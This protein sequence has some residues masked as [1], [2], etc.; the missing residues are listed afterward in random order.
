MH[1][2]EEYETNDVGEAERFIGRVYDRARFRETADPFTFRQQ[3]SGGATVSVAKYT[4]SSRSELAVEV[5]GALVIGT[6]AGADFR[7]ATNGQALDTTVPFLYRPGLAQSWA[8]DLQSTLVNLDLQALA[9]HAG[10][11]SARGRLVVPSTS[12]VTR[13]GAAHWRH[14]AAHTSAVFATPALVGNDLVRRATE[15]L[16]L[17]AAINSF[18]MAVEGPGLQGGGRAL[19][20]ALRRATAY[21]DDNADSPMG[22]ADIAAAAR[23]SVRSLQAVFRRELGVTPLEYVR[24]VR[25]SAARAELEGATADTTTL[26]EVA[27][28]WGF[29][30]LGRF[31]RLYRETYRELPRETLER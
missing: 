29:T 21:V 14:V 16:V 24:G 9:L 22:V 7:G 13:E 27:H 31:T 8:L 25:L 4:V 18:G 12:P 26:T 3:V 19:P 17:A 20:A 2:H 23:T 30:N 5:D 15:D 1:I 28:R 11:D 10:G 6:S